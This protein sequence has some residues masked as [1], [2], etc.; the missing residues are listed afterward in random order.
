[1]GIHAPERRHTTGVT[2]IRQ[3]DDFGDGG[4]YVVSNKLGV[5]HVIRHPARAGTI[6]CDQDRSFIPIAFSIP[7]TIIFSTTHIRFGALSMDGMDVLM[8]LG[9]A[10]SRLN[11]ASSRQGLQGR[12]P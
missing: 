2:L 12:H 5:R 4:F 9:Y 3:I 8:N 6:A 11:T 7:R 1:M 10:L